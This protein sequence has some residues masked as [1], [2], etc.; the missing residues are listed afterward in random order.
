M[1][2]HRKH[3][4][5]SAAHPTPLVGLEKGREQ[6]VEVCAPKIPRLWSARALGERVEVSKQ[7]LFKLHARGLLKGYRLPSSGGGKGPL[8]FAEEDL[9]SLLREE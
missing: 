6:L 3:T 7:Y 4:A 1:S 2:S 5:I 9:L 8:R